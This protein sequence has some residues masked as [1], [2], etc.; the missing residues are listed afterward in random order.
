MRGGV[1]LRRHEGREARE[2][3]LRWCGRIAGVG[4]VGR[5]LLHAATGMSLLVCV[6]MVVLWVRG[7]QSVDI[8]FSSI[9]KHPEPDLMEP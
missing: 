9:G 6:S 3:D 1:A 2:G 5:I 7:Y 8:W 4:R